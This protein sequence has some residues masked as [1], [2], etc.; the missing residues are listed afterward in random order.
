MKASEVLRRYASGERDFRS[1]NLRGHSFKGQNLSG[2][3]FSK[4]DIRG[5]NF[6]N[7]FLRE[8]NF[9]GARAGVQKRWLVILTIT[10]W[11]VSGTSGLFL[12]LAANLSLYLT[13]TPEIIKNITIVPGLASLIVLAAFLGVAYRKG[14]GIALMFAVIGIALVGIATSLFSGAIAA[15]ISFGIAGTLTF[16]V[17]G[18][19]SVAAAI[20]MTIA[21]SG[22]VAGAIS[23][24]IAAT[25][26]IFIATAT[27]TTVAGASFVSAFGI[28]LVIIL[29]SIS[30]CIGWYGINSNE[31]NNLLRT[32]A[33]GWATI[34]GTSFRNTNLTYANFS[35][36][37]L[38]GSDLRNAL[39]NYTNWRLARG[40]EQ[41]RV[42]DSLLANPK[43]L[44]L[45]VTKDGRSESY[46]GVDLHNTDLQG[47][48]LNQANLKRADLSGAILREANLAYSN[49]TEVI[50]TGTDFTSAY[51]TGA[52]IQDWNISQTTNFEGVGCE[53]V[54]FL[55]E[56]NEV[57][58]RIRRPHDPEKIF[59]P[60]DFTKLLEGALD[61][62]YLIFREGLNRDAFAQALTTI[63]TVVGDSELSTQSIEKRECG[64]F[65][66]RMSLPSGLNKS[67]IERQ[68]LD[69]YQL[70]LQDLEGKYKVE[71]QAKDRTVD[72][73]QQQLGNLEEIIEKL[74]SQP[75]VIDAKQADEEN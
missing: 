65:L 9:S 45:L 23:V 39:L 53:Y 55:E 13:F 4:A 43:V 18:I 47:A 66:L 12:G 67:E 41:S 3:D 31:K 28:T 30:C 29:V 37:K 57:G 44:A 74:A 63:Q 25:L 64:D 2:A 6:T 21:V 42:G 50:A 7:A 49:L 22:A 35:R 73:Y 46:I 27:A 32:I 14:F 24:A 1:T 69:T 71:L 8:T 34:G 75:I 59:A 68:L 40:L 10:S 56:P 51:I 5:T 26:A 58:N 36:A 17:A 38:K 20:S 72:I 52:C 19:F 61:T 11:L 60:G 48:D 62:V 33:I 70:A 16:A 15:S 54:Y